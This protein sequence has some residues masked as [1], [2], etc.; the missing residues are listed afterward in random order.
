MFMIASVTAREWAVRSEGS[1]GRLNSSRLTTLT[2]R[3]HC[4][5][6]VRECQSPGELEGVGLVLAKPPRESRERGT[7][8]VNWVYD[9]AVS[10]LVLRLAQQLREI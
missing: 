3:G 2:W 6:A 1:G 8:V 10:E 5:S 4:E 7:W 9:V